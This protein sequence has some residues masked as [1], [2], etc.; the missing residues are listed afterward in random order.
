M[1]PII[2]KGISFDFNSWLKNFDMSSENSGLIVAKDF[3]KIKNPYERVALQAAKKYEVTAVY[4]RRFD[5]GRPPIP[6]IYIY[7]Y[8]QE[9]KKDKHQ[10]AELH[11]RL[12]NA[13]QV[14]LFF[15][16]T[17]TDVKIFNCLRQPDFSKDREEIQYTPFKTLDAIKIASH[18]ESEI[19]TLRNFSAKNFDNGIFW[20]TPIYQKDFQFNNS[21]YEKLLK[22]LKVAKE[23]II[24]QN[25]IPK[26]IAQ[27]LLVM[28]ILVKYLEERKDEDGK[29]VFTQGSENFFNQFGGASNFIEV[30]RIKGA[31]LR[32]FDKLSEHFNGEI[33][34]WDDKEERDQLEKADLSRFSLFLEGKTE[35]YQ[36]VLWRL[37][38]FNDLPIELISNIYEDFLEYKSGVVYTPPHL[39]N[40]LIDECMPLEKPKQDFK[41][42]DPA[43]GS[44]IFLVAAFKRMVYWW[45]SQNGWKT[46]NSENL[47]E[48]KNLLKKNIYG[49]D[50]NPEAVR[51]TVFSLCLALCDMLSPKVIWEKLRFDV[52][53][54][55]SVFSRDFFELV[56]NNIIQKHFDLVIGNP[57]FVTIPRSES[58]CAQTIES[59]RQNIRPE[60]PNKQIA[61]LFLDQVITLCKPKGLLCLILPSSAFL[62]N[63]HSIDFRKWFFE[64][65]NVPQIIDFTHIAR[66]LFKKRI[67]GGADHATL[68]IFAQ[69]ISPD[70]NDILHVTVRR[71]KA[72]KE[73][74]FF[75]IDK[76]DFHYVP[77]KL[78]LTDKL[79]WKSNYLGGGRIHYHVSRLAALRSLGKYINIKKHDGWVSGEG[80][81]GGSKSEQPKE[82]FKTADYLTGKKT[83]PPDAFSDKGIDESQI[84]ILKEKYFN[85]PRKRELFMAPLLLMKEIVNKKSMIIKLLNEDFAFN[86]RIIG[87]HVPQDHINELKKI[88]QRL[89][90]NKIY[91]FFITAF[92]SEYLV[93]KATSC[94]KRDID[95]LPYPEDE[96][97][98]ELSEVEQI[99]IDDVLDYFREFR[100]KGENSKAVKQTSIKQLEQFGELYCKIL[101]SIYKKFKPS[102][103]IFF[104]SGSLVCYPFYYEEQPVISISEDDIENHLNKLLVE[105]RE[106]ANLRIIRILTLYEE[107]VIYLVKPN[108][109]RFWLRSVAIRDADETAFDLFSQGY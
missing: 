19:E 12:W 103:P 61:L 95:H 17:K 43:C 23:E 90:N 2:P 80:Y 14:P 98:L 1:T 104:N 57:P 63:T 69:N 25:I 44:G 9:E 91:P 38:S 39:V 28:S 106:R 49:V 52:L 92:S 37:Y 8:T 60:I 93:T 55:T 87:I 29:T 81:I 56:Q 42:L 85:S 22:E 40:F 78:A 82:N 83:F 77:K 4:F 62:Y 100:S 15:I 65:Y 86:H 45:M 3:Q 18:I 24:K 47:E 74:L 75:E 84:Y 58:E 54:D 27:K 108:Q 59:T 32:L 70:E 6:Q 76:Y 41:V 7:D 109:L 36:Y 51:L 46:P 5:N 71:T 26:S 96:K 79:I 10:I 94:L 107:N 97:Q 102:K 105:T 89:N 48:L 34:K 33:F 66:I 50:V 67:S 53:S 16:F 101:N 20:E 30:L 21:A 99:L 13:G 35:G 88:E 73:K 64:N 11:R 31:C 72:V 68:A